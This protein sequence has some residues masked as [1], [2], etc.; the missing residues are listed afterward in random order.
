MIPDPVEAQNHTITA[1]SRVLVVIPGPSH[2]A[3][4]LQDH[5]IPAP[6]PLDQVDSGTDTR[7]A[8]SNDNHGSS[9][10]VLVSH[11]GQSR[12]HGDGDRNSLTIAHKD[13][14]NED[15]GEEKEEGKGKNSQDLELRLSRIVIAARS[16]LAQVLMR[17]GC[18]GIKWRYALA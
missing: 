18:R 17:G 4:L 5:E 8:R 15:K 16:G 3:A 10:E 13:D 1:T 6:V 12:R 11:N 14:M 9:G 2:A 7:N